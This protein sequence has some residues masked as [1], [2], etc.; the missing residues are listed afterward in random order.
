[1]KCKDQFPAKGTWL[2]ARRSKR[3]SLFVISQNLER[4]LLLK[5]IGIA[6]PGSSE[7]G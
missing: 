2:K 7:K 5:K 3:I 4:V 6:H 1:M